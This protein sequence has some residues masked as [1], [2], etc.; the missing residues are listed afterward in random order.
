MTLQDEHNIVTMDISNKNLKIGIET[1]GNE[2]DNNNNN[3][4]EKVA[5]GHHDM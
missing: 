2:L 4:L 5:C 1:F 3:A